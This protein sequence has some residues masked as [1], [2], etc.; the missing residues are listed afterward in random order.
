MEEMNGGDGTLVDLRLQQ[1]YS[2]ANQTPRNWYHP[3]EQ[4]VYIL[5]PQVV[6]RLVTFTIMYVV[7]ETIMV[8]K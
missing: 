8:D 5:E 1:L 3:P 2:V 6:Q 4:I 7:L